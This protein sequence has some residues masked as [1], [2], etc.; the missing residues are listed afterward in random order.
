MSDRNEIDPPAGART[1]YGSR[2][3]SPFGEEYRGFD[4]RQDER[5]KGPLILALAVGVVLVFGA[6]VW[7]AFNKGLRTEED[8]PMILADRTPIKTPADTGTAEASV[9][10]RMRMFD[11][12]SAESAEE[13]V[14]PVRSREEPLDMESGD[15]NV[16]VRIAATQPGEPRD[17]LGTR[18]AE[19]GAPSKPLRNIPSQSLPE[20]AAPEPTLDLTRVRERAAA[21]T[22]FATAPARTVEPVRETQP[23]QNVAV[24]TSGGFLVQVAALR[25]EDAA[26]IAW[27]N[28]VRADPDLFAGAELDVQRADLGDKGIYYRVR[29]AA[30]PSRQ[31]ADSFC[32]TLKQRGKGCMVVSRN[33]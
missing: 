16:P 6:I 28:A 29:A 20:A 30:F 5:G 17:L 1:S 18:R 26:E 4:A 25:S 21:N 24:D 14:R 3:A 8:V 31:A 12:F 13:D 7:N 27:K 32:G 2:E 22:P 11:E 23:V 10:A 15:S 19:S 33:S 9:E